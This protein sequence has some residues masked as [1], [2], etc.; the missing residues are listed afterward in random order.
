MP[1]FAPLR[2]PPCLTASV[3]E[4][5]TFI[6]LIGPEATPPVE[7]TVAPEGLSRE[8]ENPVPPPLL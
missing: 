4:L 1:I 5:N 7:R 3:A 8:N 2:V 6:K